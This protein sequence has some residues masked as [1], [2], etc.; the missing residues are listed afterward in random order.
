MRS[1]KVI[2]RGSKREDN[3]MQLYFTCFHCTKFSDTTKKKKKKVGHCT[4]FQ[5]IP[6]HQQAV[7][8]Q[9]SVTPL[10][11]IKPLGTFSQLG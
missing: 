11:E 6:G 10:F 8:Q 7:D 9:C 4:V 3:K 1:P 5:M 2:P